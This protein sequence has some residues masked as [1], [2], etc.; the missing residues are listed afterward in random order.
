MAHG[1][2]GHQRLRLGDGMSEERTHRLGELQ[3]ARAPRVGAIG[4]QP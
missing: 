1:A 4:E 3:Y 2:L